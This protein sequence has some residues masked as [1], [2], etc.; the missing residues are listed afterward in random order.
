MKKYMFLL[1][2]MSLTMLSCE[3]E[4]M[5]TD[6]TSAL[7]IP[8]WLIGNYTGYHT[9]EDLNVAQDIIAFR[10]N[11]TLHVINNQN[12]VSQE[13]T[14]NYYKIATATD[15]FIFNKTSLSTEVNLLFNDLNL[16]WFIKNETPQ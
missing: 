12:I 13:E 1:V 14:V 3:T 2:I 15:V 6:T 8:S 16:G 9:N 10:V 7:R 11:N 5:D 4:S